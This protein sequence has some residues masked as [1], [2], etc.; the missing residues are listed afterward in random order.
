MQAERLVYVNGEYVPESEAKISIFD[1]ALMFGDMV[2]EM[3]RTFN[4]K[5]FKMREHLERLYNSIKMI[6]IPIDITIDEMEELVCETDRMNE[7]AFEPHDERRVM[8]NV[9]R[10][11]LSIYRG[12]FGGKIEPTVVISIFPLKWTVGAVGQL[13]EEGIHAYTPAQRQIPAQLLDPKLKNRSRLHYLMA[14]IQVGTHNDPYGWALLL[15]PDG[16]I[17]EGTGSNFFAVKDGKLLTPEPRNILRG[18][19]RQYVLELAQD[20]GIPAEE[21]N[22]EVYD[23]ATSNEAFFT[24][25]P[26]CMTPCTQ[27]NTYTIGDG[28]MGPVTQRL[29]AEW[30][31]RVGVDIVEQIRQFAAEAGSEAQG[32]TNPYRFGDARKD[33]D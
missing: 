5:H 9:S 23:V 11:P 21:K 16:F 33:Q 6:K 24:S 17:C 15:D 29:L 1:S 12:V 7:G 28:T 3:T 20:L 26:F 10:G 22:I 25:T 27:V 30:S 2:F 4:Q 18:I 32:L 14:N 13:Y 19:S 8:I 31:R